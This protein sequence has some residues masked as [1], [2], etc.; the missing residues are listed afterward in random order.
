VSSFR[1]LEAHC[2][3]IIPAGRIFE[4]RYA[5]LVAQDDA[6]AVED[7][8][9]RGIKLARDL[10]LRSPYRTQDGGHVDGRDLMDR[11]IEQRA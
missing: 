7:A 2:L 8:S 6:G 9:D 10:R 5:V 3:E 1:R 11:A 4:H